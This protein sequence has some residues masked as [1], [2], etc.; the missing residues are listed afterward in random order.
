MHKIYSRIKGFFVFE[1]FDGAGYGLWY[2]DGDEEMICEVTQNMDH[3]HECFNYLGDNKLMVPSDD[4]D[5]YTSDSKNTRDSFFI[6]DKH[7]G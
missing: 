4:F 3:Y 1:K 7:A 5:E 6:D 2:G